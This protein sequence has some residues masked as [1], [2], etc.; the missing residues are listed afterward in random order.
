MRILHIADNHLD[1]CYAEAGLPPLAA[2]QRREAQRATFQR[3]IEHAAAWPADAVLIAGDLFEQA[4]VGRETIAFLRDAFEKLR[5][6]PVFIAPGN[7]DPY[8]PDSPYASEPWP[9]NVF[10]FSEAEWRSHELSNLPLTV[11]GFAATGDEDMANPFGNLDVPD[12][13]RVHVAVGHGAEKRHLPPGQKL[14]VPFDI[15]DAL[16]AGLAYLALGHYHV[17]LEVEGAH[18]RAWYPGAPEPWDFGQDGRVLEVSLTQEKKNTTVAVEAKDFASVQFEEHTVDCT[19]LA[20]AQ[21][22]IQAIPSPAHPERQRVVRLLIQGECPGDLRRAILE[23]EESAPDGFELLLIE[24]E[25]VS[26]GSADDFMGEATSL[27]VFLQRVEAELEDTDDEAR[28]VFLRRM[29]EIGL[30]AYQDQDLPVQGLER[31]AV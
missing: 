22:V 4:Y 23:F 7:W 11:H 1:H 12:D 3:V 30:A 5:P 8:T 15:A 6:I 17:P 9:A 21:Q 31:E 16:P 27:G 24:D 20:T 14:F 26:G 2:Q 10:I 18:G 19:G 28:R 13:G 29:R 25:T